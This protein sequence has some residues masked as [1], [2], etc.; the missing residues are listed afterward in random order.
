MATTELDQSAT[1]VEA[2]L[3]SS[4]ATS[5]ADALLSEA[6][7]TTLRADASRRA[8]LFARLLAEIAAYMQQF[9]QERPWTFEAFVGTDGSAIFRGQTGRSIVVD[10]LGTLWRARSYEDFDTEYAITPT[11]CT[12][13]SLTPRYEQ[14]HAYSSAFEISG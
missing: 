13:A 2:A 7:A 1:P 11:T 10:P 6:I 8:E 5:P 12:I 9:P 14:M 3:T 4:V